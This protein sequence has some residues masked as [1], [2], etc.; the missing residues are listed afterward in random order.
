MT[1]TEVTLTRPDGKTR[2]G[3]LALPPGDG[4]C[5]GLVVIHDIFGFTD[6][7]TRQ[8]ERFSAAGFAALAPGLYD[9]GS[10][11]CVVRT[12]LDLDGRGEAAVSIEAARTHLAGLERVDAASIGVIGFCLGG[13]FA[14]LAGADHAYAVAAPFYGVVPARAERLDG[15]CPTLAFFGQRDVL[16]R[17]HARRLASHFEAMGGPHRVEVF[18][19]A[20]HSFMNDHRGKWFAAGGPYTPMQA[21]YSE[22]AEERAFAQL[23]DFFSAHLPTPP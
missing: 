4:P 13:G 3:R 17:S 2:P 22:E 9:G 11:L 12:L 21:R 6:D 15:L 8:V 5:P 23:L 1:V 7:I 20:G 19:D 14:L 16:F 10:P 18:D